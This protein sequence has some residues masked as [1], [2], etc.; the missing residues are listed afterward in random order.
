[1]AC[2]AYSMFRMNPKNTANFSLQ[3]RKNNPA[4]DIV[5]VDL[6]TGTDRISLL[7]DS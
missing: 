5:I 3:P 1:M 4:N 6:T 2:V 7:P